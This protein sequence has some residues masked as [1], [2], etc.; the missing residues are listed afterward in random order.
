VIWYLTL[1]LFLGGLVLLPLF[2]RAQR[3]S[4]SVDDH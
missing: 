2:D 3:L 4:L 1:I